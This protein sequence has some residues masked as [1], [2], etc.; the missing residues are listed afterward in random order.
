[1]MTMLKL[2]LLVSTKSRTLF[3]VAVSEE[4]FTFP[5]HHRMDHEAVHIDQVLFHQRVEELRAP[6]MGELAYL[7]IERPG[8]KSVVEARRF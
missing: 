5:K 2:N 7:Y 4:A 6:R 1:M 8:L 3:I